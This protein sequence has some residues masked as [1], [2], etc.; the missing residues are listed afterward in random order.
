MWFQ[1]RRIKWRKQNLEKQQSKLQTRFHPG[2]DSGSDGDDEDRERLTEEKTADVARSSPVDSRVHHD[3]SANGR[4]DVQALTS[5]FS[6]ESYDDGLNIETS[7]VLRSA[8]RGSDPMSASALESEMKRVEERL[9]MRLCRRSLMQSA[10]SSMQLMPG[11]SNL[12]MISSIRRLE[13]A[14]DVDYL[15]KLQQ[16]E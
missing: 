7:E 1:N 16:R 9:A 12:R 10:S 8:V 5:G 11:S 3:T 6:R 15:T 14:H 2:I 4:L 13:S